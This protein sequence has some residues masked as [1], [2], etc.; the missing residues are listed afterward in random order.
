[1]CTNLPQSS[2]NTL[3]NSCPQA[4]LKV[5]NQQVV[6]AG[7]RKE[8]IGAPEAPHGNESEGLKSGDEDKRYGWR[9]EKETDLGLSLGEVG[10]ET[11]GEKTV[12]KVGSD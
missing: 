11:E 9:R 1:M 7:S 6:W 12:I 3:K 5:R 10:A 8:S 4:G 2:T